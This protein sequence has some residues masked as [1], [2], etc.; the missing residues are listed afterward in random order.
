M[1][2]NKYHGVEIHESGKRKTLEKANDSRFSFLGKPLARMPEI[3]RRN[4]LPAPGR[5]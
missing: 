2:S 4:K 3:K 1:T 5:K